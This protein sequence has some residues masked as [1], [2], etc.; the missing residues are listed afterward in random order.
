MKPD[1]R[2]LGLIHPGMIPKFLGD[3]LTDLRFL[4][5][6]DIPQT[7]VLPVRGSFSDDARYHAAIQELRR[8]RKF[9][10]VR[11]AII[12]HEIRESLGRRF[13]TLWLSGGPIT[14]LFC[15]VVAS[16]WLSCLMA[17]PHIADWFSPT[18]WYSTIRQ[19]WF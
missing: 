16:N 15:I 6:D 3:L 10:I 2:F 14:L 1:N 17:N 13:C 8:L 7:F 11:E 18:Y 19:G 9:A 5:S 12:K 4:V